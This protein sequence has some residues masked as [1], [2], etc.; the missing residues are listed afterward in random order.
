MLQSSSRWFLGP[1]FLRDANSDFS[2]ELD[3]PDF[4]TDE[5]VRPYILLAHLEIPVSKFIVYERF[6]NWQRLVRTMA[7]VLR[8][9]RNA[10]LDRQ[11][12]S[13]GTL[14]SDELL[15]AE[16]HLFAQA[17]YDCFRE[18]ISIVRW[19]HTAPLDKQKDF[20]KASIIRTCSPYLDEFGVFRVMGRLDNAKAISE[21]ARR[22]II[23]AKDHYIT[24]L[25]V[26]WYHRKYLHLHHQ[27]VL[28][29]IRQKFW[30]PKMRIVLNSIRNSCQKCKNTAATPRI[31]EMGS[32]PKE[33]FAVFTR[34]FTFAGIDYFGPIKVI[35]NRSTQK[36]WGAIFTCLT[37]RAIH[38]EIAHSM[39]TSSCIM[40]IRNFIGRTFK[41]FLLIFCLIVFYPNEMKKCDRISF[42]KRL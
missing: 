19:N 21:S 38:L 1:E 25:V 9:I 16:N 29:E 15:V 35:V 4:T 7:Y 17:Q 39:D 30:I 18:E 11:R 22:P 10:K 23:L 28:N 27:T 3:E 14:S 20:D 6:S 41:I 12:R 32:I 5:E 24:R 26:H 34:P 31:P 36:R 37:T 40:A 33:R 8:F 13:F 2:F 42:V